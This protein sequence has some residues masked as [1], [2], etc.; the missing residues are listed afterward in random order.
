MRRVS[1]QRDAIGRIPS[2]EGG[3]GG[4]DTEEGSLCLVLEMEEGVEGRVPVSCEL[5][6]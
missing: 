2:R 3:R 5:L 6:S 4:D 1:N